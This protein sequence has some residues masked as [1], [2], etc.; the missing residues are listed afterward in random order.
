M[1]DVV[2]FRR[3]DDDDKNKKGGYTPRMFGEVS[4]IWGA[5]F[6]KVLFEKDEAEAKK[7]AR[8]VQKANLSQSFG[9]WRQEEDDKE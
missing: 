5:D 3:K 9:E 4:K 2:P 1:G 7:L 8:A 6:D